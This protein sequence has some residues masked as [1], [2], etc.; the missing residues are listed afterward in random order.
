VTAGI[1]VVLACESE[2]C[3]E[4]LEVGW[5]RREYVSLITADMYGEGAADDLGHLTLDG[6][7]AVPR[8]AS[9]WRV[10]KQGRFEYTVRCPAHAGELDG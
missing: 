7:A 1:D 6:A 2:G 5:P 4:R 3:S 9:K 8:S 10:G